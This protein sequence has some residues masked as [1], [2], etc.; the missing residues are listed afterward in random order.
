ML[1][2][3]ASAR[4]REHF[5]YHRLQLTFIHEC[6]DLLKL[7]SIATDNEKYPAHAVLL[8]DAGR[9]R[10][11]QCD[12]Y[13]TFSQHAPGTLQRFAADR[14]QHNIDV[15]QHFFEGCGAVVNHIVSAQVAYECSVAPGRRG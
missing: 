9:N 15:P 4:K 8:G 12:Q 13:A 11:N 14:V 2:S 6:G 1:E 5:G 7:V 10:R 3:F